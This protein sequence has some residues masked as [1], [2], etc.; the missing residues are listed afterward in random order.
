M[1]W[2]QTNIIVVEDGHTFTDETT[3]EEHIVTKGNM[4]T[5][6]VWKV[7]CVQSDYDLIQPTEPRTD[8][9]KKE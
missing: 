1:T 3:G 4:V 5:E 7:Y 9:A 6:G 2:G 8:A